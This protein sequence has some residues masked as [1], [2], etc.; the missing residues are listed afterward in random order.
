MFA[1]EHFG[2]APDV[3]VLAK[4]IASGLPLS[5]VVTRSDLAGK[6]RTGTH[7][8]TYGG[9]AVACAAAAATVEALVEERLVENAAER[10]AQ[11][12]AGLRSLQ[13]EFPI[14][15]DVRG[16]G[17]M[18]GTEFTC[19]GQPDAAA[20]RSVLSA[21]REE[22]LLLLGCGTYDNVVR[23]IPPLVVDAGQVDAALT[24]FRRSL[25]GL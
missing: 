17:L 10:G 2:V 14:I 21:C 23:W 20:A 11:L 7:G 22:G 6:W 4:G 15:G 25:S 24:T 1:V 12:C 13:R 9:N 16:L 3:M 8:G 18:I 19:N 5:A